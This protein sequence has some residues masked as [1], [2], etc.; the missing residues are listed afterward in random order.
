MHIKLLAIVVAA[1]SLCA[2]AHA[3]KMYRCGNTFQDRACDANLDSNVIGNTRYSQQAP[4]L[5]EDAQCSQRGL[6]A[7]KIMW[8]REAGQTAEVQLSKTETSR[9]SPELINAVYRKRG[10]ALEVR[11]AIETDCMT[12]RERAL[13]AAALRQAADNLSPPSRAPAAQPPQAGNKEAEL[14]AATAR[15]QQEAAM[16]KALCESITAAQKKTHDHQR[17]GGSADQMDAL[18]K[19]M[20][21]IEKK[22]IESKC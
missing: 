15:E 16:R 17:T 22:R 4:K 6:E 5:V 19:E 7:Q 8:A 21:E 14:K 12:E 20:R 13:Q 11:A 3:Q 9:F 1:S 10:T 2:P 18:S